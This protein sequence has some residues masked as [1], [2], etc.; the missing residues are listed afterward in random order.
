MT[1]QAEESTLKFWANDHAENYKKGVREE[2][3]SKEITDQ[4]V[5]KILENAPDKKKLRILD[6]GTGPGFFTINFTKLGHDVTGVDVTPDMIRVAKENAQEQGVECDFKIMNANSLDFPDNTFDLIISRNVTWTLPDL[7]E[8]YREWRRALAPN[9]RVIVFDSNHYINLFDEKEA[10]IMHSSMREHLIK[11]VEDYSDYYDFHVRWTYWEERPMVGTPRPQWD[12]NM[13]YKLRYVNIIAEDF[14]ANDYDSRGTSSPQFIIVAEKPSPMQENNYIV[15]EY[16]NGISGCESARAFK[17]LEDGSARK[18]VEAISDGIVGKKV[19]DLGTGSGEVAIE[20]SKKGYDVTGIDRA[21]AMIDMAKLTAEE[22]NVKVDFKVDDGES[23]SFEDE[24]FDTVIVRNVI[25]CSFEPER[26]LSEALRVLRKGGA[27]IITDGNVQKDVADWRAA[28]PDSKMLPDF[29]RRN[30]GLGAYDVIDIY[31][32]RLPL[33]DVQR[34][35]WDSNRLKAMGAAV[36]VCKEFADPMKTDD[37]KDIL[38][39]GFIVIAKK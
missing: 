8:C 33:N 32:G 26:I 2:L 18:Y 34:P 15:N 35:S 16:W 20:L 12:K 1:K 17:A 24:A 23:L 39:S 3:N 27:L 13:L 37:L 38:K 6:I 22:Q 11:G 36:D 9:G 28:N 4:W 14:S 19:L 30:L 7:F 29:K 21:S 5:R 25:W 31:Y 10:K